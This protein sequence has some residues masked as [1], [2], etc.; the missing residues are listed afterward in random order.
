MSYMSEKESILDWVERGCARLMAA[1]GGPLPQEQSPRVWSRK[2]RT[3]P[4]D[5]ERI[6]ALAKRGA[7]TAQ[8]IATAVGL[9][10][11]KVQHVTYYRRIKLP[12]ERNSGGL[13]TDR[14]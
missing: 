4:E 8:Q 11:S 7:M 10:R 1:G 6:V 5:V 14:L 13:S 12:S 3:S 9:T 2:P